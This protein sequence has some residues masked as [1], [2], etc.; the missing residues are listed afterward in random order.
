MTAIDTDVLVLGAG[1]AGLVTALA[2]SG[3]RVS[4]LHAAGTASELAQGG[5]AA[6]VGVDDSPALHAA[7]THAAGRGSNDPGAVRA[8]CDG[9]RGAVEWLESQGVRFARAGAAWSLHLEA[10]HSR[11]RVLHAGGD[12]T[13]AEIMRALRERAEASS[14]IERLPPMRA[15]SLLRGPDGIRGA[16]ALTADGECAAVHARDVVIATG[17]IGAL[18]GRTTNPASARGDGIAM[19]LAAG[20]RC[21][22]LASVQ[23][24]PTALDVPS[25]PLPLITEALRGA[26][27]RLLDEAGRPLMRGRHPLGDLAPRDIVAQAV[28][29]EQAAGGAVWLD[30]T[31][32]PGTDV[33]RSFPTAF[34]ACLRHGIDL[35]REPIPVT[36]AAHYHMGGIA[37]DLDGRTS[38]PR[39]WAVGEAACTGLHGANRLASN[40]LLEAVVFGRRLGQVLGRERDQAPSRVEAASAALEDDVP[41]GLRDLMWTWLGPVREADVIA[42][43]LA[44]VAGWRS[45]DASRAGGATRLRLVDAMLRAALADSPRARATG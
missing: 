5:I 10:A 16:T 20:A 25:H 15:T 42:S 27:A 1:A 18:F 11:A 4:V 7:D 8:A 30:A 9:A 19:A 36:C 24:H 28:H 23:F 37:V 14:H 12:A 3:R 43:G 45:R 35:R 2:A 6:A 31:A 22:S 41:D 32:L 40:S 21:A 17:G 44:T 13:G 33:A 29:R 38:L 26:G 39:L 34:H